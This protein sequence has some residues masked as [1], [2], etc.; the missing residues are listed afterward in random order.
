MYKV[1]DP[2]FFIDVYI[3]RK[4]FLNLAGGEFEEDILQR[5]HNKLR[6]DFHNKFRGFLFNIEVKRGVP[7]VR[8]TIKFPFILRKD[9]QRKIT[10][11]LR[12]NYILDD[13][14]VRYEI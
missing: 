14:D 8:F 4:Y 11:W 2:K 13:I 3:N 1:D 10:K 12:E 5:F 7:S 6:V 9:I